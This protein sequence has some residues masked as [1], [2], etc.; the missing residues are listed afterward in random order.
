MISLSVDPTLYAIDTSDVEIVKFVLSL[1]I[2]LNIIDVEV[3]YD[4]KD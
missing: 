3:V 2:P 1:P 4:S